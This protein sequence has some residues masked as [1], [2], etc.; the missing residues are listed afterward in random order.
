MVV[1]QEELSLAEAIDQLATI[2]ELEESAESRPRLL[3]DPTRAQA[4][5]REA[6]SRVMD[7]LRR[8][9][10]IHDV[11]LGS[12]AHL[13]GIRSLVDLAGKAA[14]KFDR[15]TTLFHGAQTVRLAQAKEVSELEEFVRT[16]VGPETVRQEEQRSLWEE[17]HANEWAPAAE[18]EAYKIATAEQLRADAEYELLQIYREDG[19]RYFGP[20]LLRSIR[21]SCHLTDYLTYEAGEDPLVQVHLWFDRSLQAAAQSIYESATP[22]LQ[23]YFRQAGRSRTQ[24]L[25]A[26]LNQAVM[27]LMLARSRTNLLRNCAAKSCTE[28]FYDFHTLLRAALESESYKDRIASTDLD[29]WQRL[30]LDLAHKLCGGLYDHLQES[31]ELL[32]HLQRILGVPTHSKVVEQL[33]ADHERLSNL[34]L[35]VPNGP[36]FKALD[37]LQEADLRHVPF[38]PMRQHSVPC[39]TTDISWAGHTCGLLQLAAPVIQEW[40]H[41]PVIAPEFIGFLR[42]YAA[43][44]QQHLL[45]NLQSRTAWQEESRSAALE[46]LSRSAELSPA[47]IVITLPKDN[48]FYHQ[49][50]PYQD[51]HTPDAFFQAFLEQLGS[52]DS[53]YYIPLTL[54]QQLTPSWWDNLL[55][56]IRTTW[57]PNAKILTRRQ[58]L[59]CIELT[60]TLLTL[61]L[62]EQLK[63]TTLSFTDKDGVDL[64]C[65]SQVELI[66]LTHALQEQPVDATTVNWMRLQL[67]G[68][69]L[70]IRE[71][72]IHAERF[73]RMLH[74]LAHM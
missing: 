32:G 3:K 65:A 55:T 43:A 74:A 17:E 66:A 13:E 27:A 14:R 33:Q 63:P 37:L 11:E 69:P 50:G 45:I 28:Y 57:Y 39:R 60:H 38:D 20:E 1:R 61:K 23:S 15:L 24:P 9:C 4:R 22:L 41:K 64:A 73:Q 10:A 12:R 6:L 7:H 5:T 26:A 29:G 49:V 46:S 25:V 58:R 54:A 30:Q 35:R 56:T 62:I 16:V 36:L 52:T 71:R 48:D 44:N 70:L 42:S 2:A 21:Q 18:G 51:L 59:D 67:F 72:E 8:Y 68:T 31:Q 53:G 47:L 34:L 19:T 40:I